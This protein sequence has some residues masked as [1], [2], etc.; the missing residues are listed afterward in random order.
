[1]RILQERCYRKWEAT[2]KKKALNYY[3]LFPVHADQYA[4]IL[5]KITAPLSHGHHD[6]SCQVS[7]DTHALYAAL[8]PE[9]GLG[10][11]LSSSLRTITVIRRAQKLSC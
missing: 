8:F 6:S 1:M 10:S 2:E 5:L 3:D 9:V 4:K 11:S 7:A